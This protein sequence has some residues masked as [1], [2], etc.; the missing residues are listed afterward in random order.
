VG[1]NVRE[2]TRKLE[3]EVK[4]LFGYEA[5]MSLE[6]IPPLGVYSEKDPQEFIK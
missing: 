2:L 5:G 6:A 1:I 4:E 3:K